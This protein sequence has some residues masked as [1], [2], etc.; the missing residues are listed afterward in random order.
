MTILPIL[1][2]ECSSQN[3]EQLEIATSWILLFNKWL[4]IS[5]V[6]FG[7][8]YLSLGLKKKREMYNCTEHLRVSVENIF[9]L[10]E[11]HQLINRQPQKQ[12][13]KALFGVIFGISSGKLSLISGEKL[14]IS[15]AEVIF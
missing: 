15:L 8:V 5:L 6:D 2:F 10:G 1:I 4:I 12:G 9:T 13:T 14:F 7:Y 3:D 11:G